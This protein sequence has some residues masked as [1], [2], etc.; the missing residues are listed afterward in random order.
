MRGR[1][2][3]LIEDRTRI[4]AAVS[5]DLCTPLQLHSA[6]IDDAPLGA[7]MLGELAHMTTMVES[8]PGLFTR[9]QSARKSIKA[10]VD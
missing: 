7:Q 10:G 9:R 8:I 3:D 6:F 2:K 4:L 5:H 1:I